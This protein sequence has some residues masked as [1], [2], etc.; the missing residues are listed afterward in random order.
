MRI[1][2][3]RAEG[4]S[5]ILVNTID[6]AD[7]DWKRLAALVCAESSGVAGDGFAVLA[8]RGRAHFDMRSF[9]PDGTPAEAGEPLAACAA[10]SI[11]R[12]Y[13]YRSALL[14]ADGQAYWTQ[15]TG[16]TVSVRP[17]PQCEDT[18]SAVPARVHV[19]YLLEGEFIG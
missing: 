15:I 18:E 9:E 8:H 12:R 13:G 19:A 5:Y 6:A 7:D 3:L 10:T 14:H 1:S 16:E 17:W 4:R 2:K 11:R